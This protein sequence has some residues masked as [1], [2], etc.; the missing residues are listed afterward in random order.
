[1]NRISRHLRVRS[2]GH[3]GD[4]RN[5]AAD[6]NARSGCQQLYVLDHFQHD[7]VPPLVPICGGETYVKSFAID[8]LPHGRGLQP[9]R[10]DTQA[11][12]PSSLPLEPSGGVR[13]RALRPLSLS[14]RQTL[15]FH[16]LPLP[17]ARPHASPATPHL[18]S[19]A[20]LLEGGSSVHNNVPHQ[21]EPL[22]SLLHTCHE[23]AVAPPS[24]GYDDLLRQRSPDDHDAAPPNPCP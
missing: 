24:R 3:G 4:H 5:S 10:L 8:V 23:G 13:Q 12:P 9:A 18:P 22:Q 2:G 20:F 1:M 7:A 15:P 11:L 6:A 17:R 19:A 21:S 14:I 16:L